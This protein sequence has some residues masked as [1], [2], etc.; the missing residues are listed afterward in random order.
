MHYPSG[1]SAAWDQVQSVA[2]YYLR[3]LGLHL[4]RKH[5]SRVHLTFLSRNSRTYQLNFAAAVRAFMHMGYFGMG[6]FWAAFG[7]IKQPS[8]SLPAGQ[9]YRTAH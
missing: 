3:S 9:G 4:F 6:R 7:R 5:D 8:L 1:R 2:H